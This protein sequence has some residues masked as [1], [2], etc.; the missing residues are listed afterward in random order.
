MKKTKKTFIDWNRNNI[1]S[2]RFYNIVAK[3]MLLHEG[4][5][6]RV[7]IQRDNPKDVDGYDSTDIEFDI[8]IND[9]QI[10]DHEG[11]QVLI[12]NRSNLNQGT[13]IDLDLTAAQRASVTLDE[14]DGY[15]VLQCDG[16][17]I[18]F[19]DYKEFPKGI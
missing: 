19:H 5:Q 17:G 16:K 9:W 10:K 13:R 11:H 1:D 7:L 4:E 15:Q 6:A 2:D 18:W 3:L 12:I 8:T 14:T